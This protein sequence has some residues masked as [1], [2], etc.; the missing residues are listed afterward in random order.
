[1]NAPMMKLYTKRS[2]DGQMDK[3]NLALS[4]EEQNNLEHNN[5]PKQSLDQYF[6]LND[7]FDQQQ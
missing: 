5:G 1:M 4:P 2:S 6:S 3:A 7:L